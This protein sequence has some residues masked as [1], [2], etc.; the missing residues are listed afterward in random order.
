MNLQMVDVVVN[1]FDGSRKE[2]PFFFIRS[3][4]I[5]YVHIPPDVNIM[6][7]LEER[8]KAAQRVPLGGEE[9]NE[10]QILITRRKREQFLRRKNAL[11]SSSK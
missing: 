5:R 11:A 7:T 4:N 10:L 6:E 8:M 2:F 3:R 9:R 1:L